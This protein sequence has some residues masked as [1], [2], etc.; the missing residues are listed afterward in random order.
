MSPESD[1][2]VTSSPDPQAEALESATG[3]ATA[4][5][6]SETEAE[7]AP[8]TSDGPEAAEGP[9]SDPEGDPSGQNDPDGPQHEDEDGEPEAP[10]PKDGPPPSAVIEEL[11]TCTKHELDQ[12]CQRRLPG[13]DPTLSDRQALTSRLMTAHPDATGRTE[14]MEAIKVVKMANRP[15]QA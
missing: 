4:A 6:E 14:L 5:P 3:D 12:V 7:A 1:E 2:M 8:S 10:D 9:H 15:S 11:K 13:A